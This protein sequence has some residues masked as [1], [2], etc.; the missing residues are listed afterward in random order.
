MLKASYYAIPIIIVLCLLWLFA[1]RP[2]PLPEETRVTEHGAES[3]DPSGNVSKSAD[4]HLQRTSPRPKPKPEEVDE[5]KKKGRELFAKY[6]SVRMDIANQDYQTALEKLEEYYNWTREN[7]YAPSAGVRASFGLSYWRQLVAAYPPAAD[8]LREMADD[9]EETMRTVPMSEVAFDPRAVFSEFPQE[10]RD[11]FVAQALM[12]DLC[13][14]NDV[15]GTPERSMNLLMDLAKDDPELVMSCWR[16]AEDMLYD[17]KAYDILQVCIPDLKA[18]HERLLGIIQRT[19]DHSLQVMQEKF[20]DDPAM[21]EMNRKASQA[22]Q[23]KFA[24]QNIGRLLE[25]GA[26]TGQ[27]EL[28]SELAALSAEKFPGAADLFQK[29]Q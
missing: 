29:Y 9:L 1:F 27:A 25:F 4:S 15:L 6:Q 18:E 12:S 19:A 5:I 3:I 16:G 8:K 24:A 17:A 22:A 26:A 11:A 20:K 10:V 23:D 7:D 21:Q 14:F 2:N 13:N 28:V